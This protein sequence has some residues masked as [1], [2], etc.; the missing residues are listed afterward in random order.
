MA[1][2]AAL[3]L[4]VWDLQLLLSV[5]GLK[6]VVSVRADEQGAAMACIAALTHQKAAYT[7]S[8]RPLTLVA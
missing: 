3:L 7:S 2:I 5:W 4:T 1:C 8:L 6:L